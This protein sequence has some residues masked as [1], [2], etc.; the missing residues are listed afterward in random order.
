MVSFTQVIVTL[1]AVAGLA[2]AAPCGSKTV[3]RASYSGDITYYEPGLG[4]CGQTNS[5]SEHVVALS[6][7]EYSGSCG[8]T[9]TITKGGKTATAKVVDKCPGCASGSIDVSSTV[10]ESIADLSVGRTTVDWSFE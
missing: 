8:K 2:T 7:S 3:K 1:T 4:A 5:D 6:P 10:F 9:I